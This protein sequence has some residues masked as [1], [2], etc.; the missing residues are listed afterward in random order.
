M[1]RLALLLGPAILIRACKVAFRKISPKHLNRYVQACAGRHNVRGLF[2][3]E[4]TAVPATG[5]SEIG[6]P[7]GG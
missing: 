5:M 4:K 7:A 2:P 3:L 6:R 1:T